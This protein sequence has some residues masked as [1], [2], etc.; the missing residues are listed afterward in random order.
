[1]TR[2]HLFRGTIVHTP[3]L[4]AVEILHNHLLGVDEQGY[5]NHLADA[6]SPASQELL[7]RT[8][9]GLTVLPA[10]SFLV[11]TFC[12]LHLHAPQ[13]LYQ[14]TGLHLPLMEWLNEYAFKAE[15]RLD[16]DP[17]LAERVYRRLAERLLEHGT[18][19]VLLFGTIGTETNLI[20]ARVMQE[21][22]VRA[23][24]GKLSMDISTRPSYVEP[25]TEAALQ[26]ARA[27]CDDCDEIVQPLPPHARLVQPV[28]TP[29][30][31]PTC[32]KP[33]LEGLGQLAAQRGVR[34]QSHMAEA[35]DQ[36]QH[37]LSEHGQDDMDVFLHSKLLTPHT[38][39]AHCT[40]LSADE[41]ARLAAT[42]TAVAHCPLSNAYFSAAP[43]RLR[44]ALDAGVRV[45]LGTDVAG[46][47]SI[48]IMSAMRHTVSVSRM[49]EGARILESTDRP[50]GETEGTKSLSVDWKEALYLATRGGASALGLPEG[51]GMFAVGAPFDAHV[52]NEHGTGKGYGVGA[53]DFFDIVEGHPPLTLTVE[54]VEKWWCLGDTRNREEVWVQGASVYSRGLAN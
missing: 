13:F 15:E 8:E 17:M 27:F 18:G 1:M 3:A 4:G 23:F 7:G 42:G 31:V 24:V 25:S 10:G 53:L 35:H 48:D 12:D 39:Q 50:K 20:L 21:A 28:L 14:G 9:H 6:S 43:F 34:V 46:G 26:A 32:S 5:I 47:Y 22:G 2:S 45:G 11:P 51:C 29:R 30:F 52:Y 54:V 16:A 40:F 33:L 49:R 36:V 19:A 44:E 41:L 38:V 37:V